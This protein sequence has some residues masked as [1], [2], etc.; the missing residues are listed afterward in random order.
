MGEVGQGTE[1]LRQVRPQD[2]K[3]FL[4]NL[5][6]QLVMGLDLVIQLAFQAFHGKSLLRDRIL[7]ACPLTALRVI[8]CPALSMFV[9]PLLKRPS[10]AHVI[11]VDLFT[12]LLFLQL[13]VS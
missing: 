3:G 5:L 2:R 1:Q 10:L 4:P 8:K 6:R 13:L 7:L 11:L 9:I 12:G